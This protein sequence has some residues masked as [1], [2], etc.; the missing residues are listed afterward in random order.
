MTNSTANPGTK[1]GRGRRSLGQLWQVPMFLLGLLAL[2][3]VAAS[4]PWRLSPQER[5]FAELVQTLREGLERGDAGDVLIGHA[6]NVILRLP[7]FPARSAEAHFLIGS[8]Y[9]RQAQHK[10]AAQAKGIW[11]RAADHLDKAFALGV[12]DKDRSALQYRLGLSLYKQN[13]EMPRALELMTLGVEKGADQPLEGLQLLV[14]AHLNKKPPDLDAARSAVRRILDLTP[15]RDSEAHANARL[16]HA[17]LLMR[18]QLRA[19]AI[20]E[21][22]R[23]GPKAS[24]GVRVKARL[25][26]AKCNEEDGRWDKAIPIWQELLA[27]AGN[28]EG[29]R[30]RILYA[31]GWC[32]HEME[33]PNYPEAIRVWSEALKQGGAEGQAAGLHLGRLRLVSSPHEASQAL[34]DWKAALEKVNEPK[35]YGNPHVK[36]EQVRDWF[37]QAIRQFQVGREPQLT[38]A[39]A[40]LYRKIA[41]GGDAELKIAEAAEAL[42][43]QLAAKLRLMQEDVTSESVWAQY[44]RA[45]DAFEHAA[46][47]RPEAE[48]PDALWRSAQCYL[49]A[50]EPAKAQRLLH[51]FVLEEKDETR[52]ADGWCT[53]GDLYRQDNQK[54]SAHKAYVKCIEYPGTRFAYRARFHLAVEEEIDNKNLDKARGILQD[55]LIDPPADVERSW[56]E[57]SAF[58]MASLLMKMKNYGEAQIHLKECLRHFSENP[59]ALLAREQLGECYRKLADNERVKENQQRL[60]IKVGMPDDRRGALEESVRQLRKARIETLTEAVKT[61]QALADELEKK[62]A[63]AKQLTNLEQI[64]LRRA[65]F[66]IGECYLDNE[67]FD[68]A[69][70]VFEKLQRKHRRTLEGFYASLRIC[71]MVDQIRQ[72]PAQA[73]QIRALAKDSVG[74]LLEDLKALPTEHDLFRLPGVSSREEWLRWA[75]D[76]QRK[77]QAP[78][79][80]DSGLPA[81]R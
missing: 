60:Q 78:P 41:P 67:E 54:E 25:L 26:Q 15:E 22:E 43:L 34:A 29:G 18:K 49:A 79:R 55:N 11:P 72:P 76:T 45:G 24:R 51:Q 31:L 35:D 21:L 56:Q 73:D 50:K 3:G 4:A 5:E 48:R 59:N 75:E 62:F 9:F 66:G 81:F 44:G 70:Q 32:H 64:L 14:Q 28:V 58:K 57:R 39:I 20:K 6:E 10:P 74:L 52:L 1:V 16:Q 27:D 33:P 71:N 38:Q 61:Y 69:K 65:W 53:L 42:A 23:I 2:I 37:A 77:L 13:T 80:N 47:A 8:V 30:A 63:G 68:G 17:E 7:R 36:I 46:N 19:E 40:E 12:A